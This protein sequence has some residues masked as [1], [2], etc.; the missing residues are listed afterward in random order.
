MSVQMWVANVRKLSPDFKGTT[1]S[2]HDHN[3]SQWVS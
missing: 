1:N 3:C 2:K